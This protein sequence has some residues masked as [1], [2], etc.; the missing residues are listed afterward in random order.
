[1]KTSKIKKVACV[2][3]GVIGASW[4]TNFVFKGYPVNIYDI[5][6]QQLDLAKVNIEKNLEFLLGKKVL[7]KKVVDK[8]KTLVKYTTNIEEAVHDVQFI[9]EAGPEKYDIKQAILAEI[10]KYTDPQTI[11]ASSTSGLLI[12]EITKYS[13]HPER[14]IGAHPY[15]PPHLIPL[16]EISKGAKTSTETVNAACEFYKAVGKEPVVLQKEALGFISNR[17][18]MALYREAIDLVMRGVC[19]VEDI[20][21]A[22]CFGPG[23]RYGIMG[24]NLI[25][26]LGGGAVGI[27]GLF[28]HV[29]ASVEMWWADMADWKKWPEGWLD[30]AQEGVN[31]EKAN[32]PAEIGR[33]TEEII[34]F[35][36]SM[37]VDLLK[38]HHKL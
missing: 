24:P 31:R 18:Q 27:K 22:A 26:E 21:K 4:A 6:Q 9:Q 25:Y 14:C 29:G 33:T 12:T 36:D 35:R 1:M 15:N 13:P 19:S 2:G 7:T 28:K 11:F 32:R 3:T 8:A 10:D 23:L 34:R 38:L 5:N 16:V 37:L 20:D 17:L 30:I